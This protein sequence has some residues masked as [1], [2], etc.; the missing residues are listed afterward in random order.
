MEG[1]IL[2]TFQSISG[3]NY[4]LELQLIIGAIPAQT[5]SGRREIYSPSCLVLLQ[6]AIPAQIIIT[7]FK[8]TEEKP[9]VLI[10]FTPSYDPKTVFGGA[11]FLGCTLTQL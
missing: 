6:A 11:R 1:Y 7:G 5:L 10:S 3:N 2:L 8:A 4:A 9:I